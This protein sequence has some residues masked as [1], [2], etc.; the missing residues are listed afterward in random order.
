MMAKSISI[1]AVVVLMAIMTPSNN[2]ALPKEPLEGTHDDPIGLIAYKP[3]VIRA[4]VEI[5][6]PHEVKG[7][8]VPHRHER[9]SSPI[10]GIMFQS[11]SYLTKALLM[12]TKRMNTGI[13][14]FD[15][16]TEKQVVGLRSRSP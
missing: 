2:R 5:S 15:N 9:S 3:V 8:K 14:T 16:I 6:A 1:L 7:P 12:T 10:L 13:K 11:A 4:K